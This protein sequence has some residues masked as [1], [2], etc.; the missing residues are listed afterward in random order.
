MGS[1]CIAYDGAPELY[2]EDWPT[3]RKTHRCCECGNEIRPGERYQKISGLWEGIFSHY[4]TC[5]RCADLRDSLS[6]V[7]CAGLGEL[8]G[9][10]SEY[11]WETGKVSYNEDTDDYIYPN[12][13]LFIKDNRAA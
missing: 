9:E 4:K 1:C 7:I 2:S 6:D 11:L 3:A 5:E 13:H 10:Y 12:N 8:K